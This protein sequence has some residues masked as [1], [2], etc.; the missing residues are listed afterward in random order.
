MSVLKKQIEKTL[1][2]GMDIPEPLVLLFSWIEENNL[3]VDTKHGRIGFLYPEEELKAVWTDTERP[4]GTIIE[5]FAE[6][7]S[8]CRTG[9]VTNG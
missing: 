1:L 2:P 5:F 6:G 4:G 8:I 3:F 7:T 9:S